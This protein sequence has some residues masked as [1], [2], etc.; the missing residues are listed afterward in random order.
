MKLPEPLPAWGRTVWTSTLGEYHL[1]AGSESQAF[2]APG[3]EALL[4]MWKG[5]AIVELNGAEYDLAHYDTLYVPLG[6]AFRL[7]NPDGEPA[8]LIQTAATAENVHPVFHSKFAEFSKREDRIRHLKGKD[9]YMM[10]DV[11]EAAEPGART[12]FVYRVTL[13]MDDG[14]YRTFSKSEPPP[15]RVGARV[16][17]LNGAIRDE[18]L[19]K[20]TRSTG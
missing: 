8:C 6:S 11:G 7:R 18:N 10:F 20:A 15:L 14:S 3:C 13:Q 12:R 17:V 4:Y 2:S 19:T 9:V 5:H 1:P 16:R